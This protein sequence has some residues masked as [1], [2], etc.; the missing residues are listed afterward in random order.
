MKFIRPTLQT[1]LTLTN[2][3]VLTA[4]RPYLGCYQVASD[5]GRPSLR[6][7]YSRLADVEIKPRFW[8]SPTLAINRLQH[9]QAQLSKA[10][11]PHSTLST[12]SHLSTRK[13]FLQAGRLGKLLL[14]HQYGTAE[15]WSVRQKLES[16]RRGNPEPNTTGTAIEQRFISA[17]RGCRISS[18]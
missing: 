13:A 14:E 17:G 1:Q 15:G 3:L 16:E 5:N 8:D 10:S 11:P 18:P 9:D 2:K 12:L 6:K 4:R 7:R